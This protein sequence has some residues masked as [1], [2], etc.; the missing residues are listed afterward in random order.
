MAFY[1]EFVVQSFSLVTS[2]NKQTKFRYQTAFTSQ[3]IHVEVVDNVMKFKFGTSK[4][5]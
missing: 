5:W 2:H 4:I 3:I 1:A